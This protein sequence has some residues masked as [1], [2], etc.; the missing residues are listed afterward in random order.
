MMFRSLLLRGKVLRHA[1][2]HIICKYFILH[3]CTIYV[4][5]LETSV[6]FFILIIEQDVKRNLFKLKAANLYVSCSVV[7]PDLESDPKLFARSGSEVGSGINHFGSGSGQPFSRTNLKQNFS[8]KFFY[9]FLTK[10][11]IHINENLF[12]IKISPKKLM[13]Q[14]ALVSILNQRYISS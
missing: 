4:I 2:S 6:F 14:K 8:N 7:D 12:F 3:Y 9:N 13:L 10:C 11:T 5:S 1:S